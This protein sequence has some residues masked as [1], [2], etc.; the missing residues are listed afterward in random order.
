MSEITVDYFYTHGSPWAYLGHDHFVEMTARHGVRVRYKPVFLGPVFEA[1]GGLPLPKRHPARRHYRL[2]ELQRWRDKRALPLNLQPAFANP[3]PTLADCAAIA[4]QEAGESP[5]D[6]SHRAFRAMWAYDKDVADEHVVEGML[7]DAG[8][9]AHALLAAAK[10]DAVKAIY[11]QNQADG[12]ALEIIGSPCY[13]LRGEPFWGQ[14]RLDLLEEAIV[15][16]RHPYA[17]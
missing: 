3:A 9:D 15:S 10:S 7:A 13:V 14:D 17:P 16:G 8:H 1:T 6:F 12:V 2:I 5:A 4:I 11:E